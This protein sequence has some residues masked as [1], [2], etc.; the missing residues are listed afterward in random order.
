MNTCIEIVGL[1]KDYASFRLSIPLLSICEG[2]VFGLVGKN[3][4]GKSTLIDLMLDVRKCSTG[5]IEI[6]GESN[7]NSNNHSKKDIG[8]LIDNADFS[9]DFSL[10]EV[11]N[12]LKSIY[13]SWDSEYY[14][15]LLDSFDLEEKDL[16]GSLSKGMLVKSKLAVA[17]AHKPRLLILDEV[18]SGIDPASRLG[19]LSLLNE[20]MN[21][22]PRHTIVF[23]T[24]ITD[25][26]IR[27]SAK[28]GFLDNGNLVF[29]KDS[30]EFSHESL[31]ETMFKYSESSEGQS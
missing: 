11:E 9:K 30:S 10:K 17:L 2:E 1:S 6:F 3:G 24:H 14:R 23:S 5:I 19:I 4:A 13:A 21:S 28:I 20:Y 16:I 26:L 15:F 18:T 31:D 29:V 25:D 8:F 27:L 22:N 12:V 7:S